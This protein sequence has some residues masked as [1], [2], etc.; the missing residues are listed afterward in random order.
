MI[1]DAQGVHPDPAKCAEIK[2]LPAPKSVTDIQ[3]FL[4][5]IQFMSPFIPN[6]ADQTAPL[7]A[8]TKAGAKFEWNSSLQTVYDNIKALICKDLALSYL[9]LTKETMIQVDTSKIGLG[10][11]LIQ[12]GRPIAFASK[13]LT[14]TEQRY[15]NIER[16]LLPVVFG[17]ERFHA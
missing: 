12:D 8:L 15:A 11:A 2:N 3:Q 1:Y 9:D 17:C 5:I 16:E 10:A 13:A 6:L 14:N 7:H 4:G